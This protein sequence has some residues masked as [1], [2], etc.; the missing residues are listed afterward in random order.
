MDTIILH[1]GLMGGGLRFG[2]LKWSSF[3]GIERKIAAG[4]YR[5]VVS[6]VHPTAGIDTRA[7]Q[8][9]KWILANRRDWD[10]GRVLLVAHSLGGLDARYL[11]SKLEMAKHFDALLTISTP[12]RGSPYADYWARHLGRK[13]AMRLLR[14]LGLD[15]NAIFHSTTENCAKLNR[16]IIDS[17]E[18]KYFSI[19]ASAPRWRV[20]P[21]AWHSWKV[22][23][24]AHGP[25]DGLVAAQSAIWGKHLETWPV[26][27]WQQINPM[28][29]TTRMRGDIS[30]RY[31]AAIKS[32]M[33]ELSAR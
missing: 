3:T 17:S 33:A 14:E 18:V 11:L 25:N 1:H 32:I 29:R 20:P 24:D 5:V 30:P 22:V 7:R 27:H 16:E 31:L 10:D 28:P 6:D 21:F 26:N 4:G 12:H 23:F 2:P 9:Q 8:L 13:P 19:S 15:L